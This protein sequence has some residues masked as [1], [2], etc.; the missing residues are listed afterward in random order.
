MSILSDPVF[1]QIYRVTRAN[2]GP[3]PDTSQK[4]LNLF[5]QDTWQIGKRLT[6]RPG[7]RWER[8]H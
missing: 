4:Y 1:G 7:V 8:Q 2:Y 5:I 3:Q 6:L